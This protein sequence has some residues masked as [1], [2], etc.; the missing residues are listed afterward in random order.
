MPCCAQ[1]VPHSDKRGTKSDWEDHQINWRKHQ[2]MG[3]LYF[4]PGLCGCVW[5]PN[6]LLQQMD[7]GYF[8]CAQICVR[9]GRTHEEGSDTNNYLLLA[10][11]TVNRSGSSPQGFQIQTSVYTRVDS[12]GQENYSAPCSPTTRGLDPAGSSDLNSDSL[13]TELRRPAPRPPP[14]LAPPPPPTKETGLYSIL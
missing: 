7:M 5:G 6:P 10:Y 3:H 8:T 13:T 1:N 11:S 4:D 9:A 12:D 14:P 2:A